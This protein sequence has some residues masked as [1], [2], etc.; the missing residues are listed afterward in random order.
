MVTR[1]N[2]DSLYGTPFSKSLEGE[3]GMSKKESAIYMAVSAPSG[4][5]KTSLCKEVLKMFPD[6]R[7]SISYTTRPPRAGEIHGKDYIFISESEFRG[8]IEKG[9]FAEWAENYG[10]LYGTSRK[11]MKEHLA[12]GRDLLLDVDPR[13]ARALKENYPGGIFVFVLPPSLEV[14][15]KRLKGRGSESENVVKRRLEKSM[16]EIKEVFWYDYVIF[17]ERID[18]AA[19]CLRS[20]YLAEKSRRERQ[21]NRI[22]QYMK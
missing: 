20:I 21:M 5:G 13:G 7:Y 15:K 17:N 10:C 9:D 8:M 18:E 2:L 3:L 12:Q 1:K 16:D 14:L 22:N 19:D 6:M 4:A 11:V